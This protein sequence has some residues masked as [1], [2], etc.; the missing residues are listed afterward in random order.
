[1]KK[2]KS[3]KHKL[4]SN[5][6]K[7]EETPSET[8]SDL[9]SSD[10]GTINKAALL[11]KAKQ[12]EQEGK[13]RSSLL[14]RIVS[15]VF[16]ISFMCLCYAGGHMYYSLFLLYAGFK[17]YFELVA[18]NRNHI[19]DSKNKFVHIL[20]WYIPLSFCFYLLPKTFIRRVL[21]ENDS[22]IDF[23]EALPNIYAMLF[24]HHGLIS[25]ALLFAGLVMFTLSLEKGQ[26]RYQFKRLGW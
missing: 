20:E 17:C 23:K 18:I 6:N 12:K 5:L 22:M 4:S 15:S 19:K 3:P 7:I 10:G 8:E 1:M 16:L 13:K 21:M 25:S 2:T 9:T 24:I 26:Y 11:L 14:I